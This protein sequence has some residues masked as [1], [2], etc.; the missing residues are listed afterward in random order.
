MKLSIKE[1]IGPRCIIKEDGQKIFD[2]IYE[3]L[4]RGETVTLD[5]NGVSQFA[6]PFFNFAIGRL[7]NNI[8]EA[9]VRRY[10]QFENLNETGNSVVERVL[11]NASK[12]HS[13]TQL[14]DIVAEILAKQAK[15]SD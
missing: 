4:M 11:E 7:L 14:R 6:T 13:N 15:G 5:F 3:P 10:L 12:Q 8:S 9:D 2:E 1:K